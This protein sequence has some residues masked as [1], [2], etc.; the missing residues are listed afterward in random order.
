VHKDRIMAVVVFVF[1]ILVFYL[2]SRLRVSGVEQDPGPAVFPEAVAIALALLAAGLF[3]AAGA[4]KKQEKPKEMSLA[5]DEVQEID[6]PVR[7]KIKRVVAC[8][9]LFAAYNLCLPLL[10][11]ITTTVVFGIVFLMLLYG[12]KLPKA[13]VPAVVI[14]LFAFVLFEIG[15]GIPLPTFLQFMRS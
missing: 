3:F 5:Q 1:A 11:F 15:F 10:G 7:E 9:A 2:S 8:I 13:F 14:T 4:K 6:E 12:M